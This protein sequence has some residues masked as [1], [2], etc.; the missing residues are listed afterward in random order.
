MIIEFRFCHIIQGFGKCIII[1]AL[2]PQYTCQ[3]LDYFGF[4]T[5]THPGN[6]FSA[7][8]SVSYI[9]AQQTCEDRPPV[10]VCGKYHWVPGP[11]EYNSY[12]AVEARGSLSK[13][14]MKIQRALG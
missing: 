1:L 12:I 6:V 7:A 2:R 10:L 9:V 3:D 14:N 4:I 8:A 13:T 5:K 11:R